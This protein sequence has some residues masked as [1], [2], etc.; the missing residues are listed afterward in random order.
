VKAT[1]RSFAVI[2][3]CLLISIPP[4]QAWNS[5]GH[6]AVAYVAYQQ[7]TP[8]VQQRV[9]VLL[10]KNPFYKKWLSYI[11]VGT[12][13]ADKNLYIF[14]MAATWPDEIKAQGSGYKMDGDVPPNTSEATRNTGYT[15]KY[16]H[17]Y[18]HFVD[19]PFSTDGTALPKEP[20]PNA[21]TQIAAFRKVLASSTASDAL[22]SYDLVWILHLVGDVHQPLHCSTRVTAGAPKGDAGGNSVKINVKPNEL[23]GYWDNQLG[24]GDTQNFT[25]AVAAAKKLS[26][27]DSTAAA[28]ANDADWVQESFTIS[29]STVYQPPIGP[30]LGPYTI[31]S[32]YSDTALAT[33]QQRVALAGARLANLL[34]TELK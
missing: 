32:S 22:K 7:L 15:D 5:I 24:I 6:M 17:K 28:D 8:A 19:L 20:V 18:W 34:N 29:K 33:A 13:A 10:A 2:A 23:H 25:T 26:P 27:A 30:A 9:A 21:Q 4:A 1:L 11:P 16:M 14:M 31:D 3:L 12:S